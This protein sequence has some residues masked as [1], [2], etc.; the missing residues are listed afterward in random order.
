MKEWM[1]GCVWTSRSGPPCF[2]AIVTQAYS[3][4]LSTFGSSLLC[5]QTPKSVLSVP[6][7]DTVHAQNDVERLEIREQTKSKSEAKWKYKVRVGCRPVVGVSACPWEVGPEESPCESR[8]HLTSCD[9]LCRQYGYKTKHVIFSTVSHLLHG[10]ISGL[11][12]HPRM[13]PAC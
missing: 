5:L 9:P 1:D 2:C 7:K 6:N 8:V 11:G 13:G 3:S 10:P 12:Q 4:S